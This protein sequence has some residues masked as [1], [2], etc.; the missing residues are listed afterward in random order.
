MKKMA[1]DY[2]QINVNFYY[3]NQQK[4]RIMQKKSCDRENSK[5]AEVIPSVLVI[6]LNISKLHSSFKIQI[7]RMNFKM[8]QLDQYYILSTRDSLQIHRHKQIEGER[9]EKIFHT[10]NNDDGTNR[11][12]VTVLITDSRFQILKV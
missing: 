2:R 7:S 6:I 1:I 10:N 12:M 9:M 8:I 3:K 4:K 11:A 5:M